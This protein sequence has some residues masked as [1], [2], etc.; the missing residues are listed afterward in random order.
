MAKKQLK[1]GK[2]KGCKG[3]KCSA[4]CCDDD[5]VEE[6][7]VEYM[8]FH[9]RMKDYWLSKGIRI[10]FLDD[11]VKFHDC[12]DGKECKFIK[13]S[14]SKDIDFR[15]IDCKI[16][17]YVVDWNMIDFDKKI[18]HLYFWDEDCPLVKNAAIPAEF[19]KEVEKIIKQ[20]FSSVF[21]G[22]KFKVKFMNKAFK[23]HRRYK[24]QF[25]LDS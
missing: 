22:A 23:N 5:L 9:D 24:F 10:E 20:G 18:V 19:K 25:K 1:E 4:C 2:L 3:S 11:R 17:P 12:S 14:P 7:V 21:H 16:Y 6:W 15:P 13:Y 8:A